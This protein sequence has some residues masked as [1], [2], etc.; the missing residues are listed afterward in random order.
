MQHGLHGLLAAAR[1]PS[2]PDGQ[3]PVFSYRVSPVDD[4]VPET[5]AVSGGFTI[6][7]YGAAINCIQVEIAT[8][9][10]TIPQ[11]ALSYLSPTSPWL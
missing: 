9:C 3:G 7:Q 6:R 8:P 1:H 10:A 5:S 2:G 11:S 4:T